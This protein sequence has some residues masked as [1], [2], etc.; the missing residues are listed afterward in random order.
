MARR[1]RIGGLA[2]SLGLVA[3]AF[4]ALV[5]GAFVA[6]PAAQASALCGKAPKAKR[7]KH[8]GVTCSQ[9]KKVVAEDVS[10]HKCRNGCSFRKV[11]YNWS[12]ESRP[13]GLNACN[14]RVGTKRYTVTFVYTG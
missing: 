14:A 2:V 8:Y 5:A 1:R 10:R 9:A 4:I 11:G 12:C 13:S 6:A 3:G 7:I